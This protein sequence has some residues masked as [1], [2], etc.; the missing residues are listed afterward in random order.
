MPAQRPEVEAGCEVRSKK[1]V[2]RA[3]PN[4]AGEAVI[5]IAIGAAYE[6]LDRAIAVH[7]DIFPEA[8]TRELHQTD[9]QIA[10]N[11]ERDQGRSRVRSRAKKD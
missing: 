2:A 1:E 11:V 10:F 8:E 4:Q 7:L 3:S 9:R 6:A 5:I